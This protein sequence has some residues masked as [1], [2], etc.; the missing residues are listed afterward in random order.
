MF[1][2]RADTLVNELQ[3][4]YNSAENVNA[5]TQALHDSLIQTLSGGYD[6]SSISSSLNGITSG[7]NGVANAARD[8]ASAIQSMGAAQASVGSSRSNSGSSSSSGSSGS[9][10]N[11]AWAGGNNWVDLK[12]GKIYDDINKIPKHAKGTRSAKAGLAI[13]DEEGLEAKFKK[14]SNG[15]FSLLGEGDQ[16]FTKAQTDSLFEWSK[17]DPSDLFKN[18]YISSAQMPKPAGKQTSVEVKVDTLMN[19]EKVDSTNIRQM[20]DIANNAVDRFAAKIDK[21]FRYGGI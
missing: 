7:L 21:Q 2:T 9:S 11:Y 13:T 17:F 18:A 10:S 19:V 16:I 15:K 14:L 6:I 5:M 12:T 8:T 4:S 3:S 20:Q 1:A